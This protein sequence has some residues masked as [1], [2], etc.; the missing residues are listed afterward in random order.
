MV[1]TGRGKMPKTMNFKSMKSYM[2]WLG[3]KHAIVGKSRKKHKPTI[4]IHGKTHRVK[5]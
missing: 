3:A 2:N 4:K 1:L 5:H